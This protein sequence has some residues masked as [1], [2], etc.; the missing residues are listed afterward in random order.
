MAE[1]LWGNVYFNDVFAGVL[2]E[3]PGD[4]CVFT[5]DPAYVRAGQPAIAHTLPLSTA[6]HTTERRLH[7]FFDNLVAEGWLGRAQARVL[8]LKSEGRFARLLAFGHDLSGAVS[9]R[10]P[11]PRTEPPIDIDDPETLAALA[12]RASISGVQPK[13][14]VTKTEKGY[15]PA[16]PKDR[17]THI[18]KLR[19][20]QLRDIVENEFLTITA[21]RELLPDDEVVEAEIAAIAHITGPALVVRRFDRNL[22]GEKIHFEEFNQLLGK[23]AEENYDGSYG[24]MARFIAKHPRTEL[25]DIERLFRRILACIL[26]GNTDA[27]LKN[28]GMLYQRG[29]MRLAPAYD[30]VAA[31]L[32]PEYDRAF[33]LRVGKGENPRTLAVE[34]KHLIEL[35]EQF[36]LRTAALE[37]AVADFGKRLEA[38]QAAVQA[39]PVENRALKDE[40][41]ELLGRRW[42]GTFKSIGRPLSRK[43][44]GDAKSTG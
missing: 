7:P 36:G 8:G 12:S 16:T 24:D 21:T 25:R 29:R 28:F 17:S 34:P 41:S 5:Y 39:A 30:L 11:Q 3:E 9:V 42:N 10:D 32:Y 20:G 27:H 33:A 40:I 6:P 38:A 19:S 18:A 44:G 31:G 13:I 14:L 37:L 2:R 23:T 22:A 15:R 35:T 26:T 4:R 1:T 43:R